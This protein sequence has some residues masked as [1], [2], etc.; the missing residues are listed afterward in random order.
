MEEKRRK[1]T[2]KINKTTK[3]ILPSKILSA[4]AQTKF[5]SAV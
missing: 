4:F 5:G 3:K 1:Q 2:V